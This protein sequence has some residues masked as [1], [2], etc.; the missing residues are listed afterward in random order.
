MV[1]AKNAA[2]PPPEPLE[3]KKEKRCNE[4]LE[5]RHGSFSDLTPPFGPKDPLVFRL[6]GFD[7]KCPRKHSATGFQVSCEA[8]FH[9][10]PSAS[11]RSLL[12]H[13]RLK[14]TSSGQD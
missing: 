9:C 11:S 6:V 4:N 14:Q 10:N 3:Q 7:S 12:V 13:L 5:F 8:G 1:A 2:P